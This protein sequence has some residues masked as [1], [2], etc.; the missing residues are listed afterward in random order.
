M[1]AA[2][3]WCDELNHSLTLALLACLLASSLLRASHVSPSRSL[4][5]SLHPSDPLI[6]LTTTMCI[7]LLV[8][9]LFDGVSK[10][11]GDSETE[12]K[13]SEREEKRKGKRERVRMSDTG[14]D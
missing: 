8:S 9:A 10:A 2:V 4:A 3:A 13:E 7:S 1:G 6:L 11:D 5:L 12:I 14:R